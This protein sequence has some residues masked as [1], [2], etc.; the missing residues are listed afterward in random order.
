MVQY[1]SKVSRKETHNFKIG[2]SLYF[3]KEEIIAWIKSG[4]VNTIAEIRSEISRHQYN[5]TS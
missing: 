1:I 4:K 5:F 2:K 3:R